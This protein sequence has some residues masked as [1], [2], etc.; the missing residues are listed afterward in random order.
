MVHKDIDTKIFI[1]AW[2][3]IVKNW[4]QLKYL[5]I[6]ERLNKLEPNG[7]KLCWYY[8]KIFYGKMSRNILFDE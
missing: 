7:R 5:S 4:E 8:L 2:L 3:K 6:R 1:A